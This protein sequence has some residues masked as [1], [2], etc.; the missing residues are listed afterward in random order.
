M[1]LYEYRCEECSLLF[2]ELKSSKEESQICK[3]VSCGGR[4]NRLMS[5]FAP[6]VAGGSSVEPVDMTVGRKANERWQQYHDRQSKRRG[7]QELKTFDLPK[8]KDGK[9]M[10]VM[11]LGDK[12]TVDGR[13]DYVGALQEHRQER[14]K[15]GVN[16]FK[17][18]GAF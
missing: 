10:P 18:S 12:K 14:S 13:K 6:V 5:A 15:K 16:Q 17:E 8:S 4:A 7:G 11:A 3:C 9:Y 2:E 1:A